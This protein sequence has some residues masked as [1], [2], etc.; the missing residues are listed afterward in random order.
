M[1]CSD[2]SRLIMN[3]K[4]LSFF[5]EVSKNNDQSSRKPSEEEKE[6]GCRSMLVIRL[7]E[8]IKTKVMFWWDVVDHMYIFLDTYIHKNVTQ[9]LKYI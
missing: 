6:K 2:G 7:W 1:I 8:F 3:Q 5:R 4:W 9:L